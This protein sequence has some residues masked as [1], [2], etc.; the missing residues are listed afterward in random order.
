MYIE[1]Q[2]P[3]DSGQPLRP[4]MQVRLPAGYSRAVHRACRGVLKV[5]AV[6]SSDGWSLTPRECRRIRGPR[7]L[8]SPPQVAKAL[9]GTA[10]LD[11][12]TI[13]AVLPVSCWLGGAYEESEG[14]YINTTSPGRCCSASSHHLR[15]HLLSLYNQTGPFPFAVLYNKH[16]FNDNRSNH[17]PTH[18]SQNEVLH[19]RSLPPRPR[20]CAGRQHHL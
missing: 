8:A 5:V 20:L 6:P 16:S 13:V 18:P 1:S 4:R 12:L 10:L 14:G 19:R 17:K 11:A 7:R 15:L 2:T 9:G 3:K